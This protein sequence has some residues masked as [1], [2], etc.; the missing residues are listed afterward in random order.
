V[1]GHSLGGGVA[2]EMAARHKV[3]GVATLGTFT[4]VVDR[5]P[6]IARPFVLDR[7]DNKAA[8]RRITAPV[9]L[10]HGEQDEIIAFSFGE[11][12]RDASGGRARFV[13]LPGEG[14]SVAMG[15]MAPLLWRA[16]ERRD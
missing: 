1:F 13:P 10:F 2:L 8:I 3:D 15:K 11:R 16:F 12:L 4:S 7:F 14:H 6:A 9:T 5:A